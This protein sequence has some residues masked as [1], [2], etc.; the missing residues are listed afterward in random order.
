MIKGGD[1]QTGIWE[2]LLDN[3]LFFELF[4]E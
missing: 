2:H 3:L 4:F 1:N